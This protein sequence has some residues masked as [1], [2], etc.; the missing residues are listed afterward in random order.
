GNFTDV[1]LKFKSKEILA[2]RVILSA[3]SEVF[4]AM[5]Q[6]NM[7]ETN[8]E[9]LSSDG[10]QVESEDLVLLTY[11]K[12]LDHDW[13]QRSNY[14]NDVFKCV[15]TGF[16]SGQCFDMLTSRFYSLSLST[17]ENI[18]MITNDAMCVDDSA[19]LDA[20]KENLQPRH[21][22]DTS[23]VIMT[24]GG[25]DGNSCLVSSFAFLPN[26]CNWAHLAPMQ[27]SRH[28]HGTVSIGNDL[29]VAGGFNSR[30]GP[31]NTT[32]HYNSMSNKWRDLGHMHFKR[33]SLGISVYQDK[34]F[35]SG[36]LDENY[37]ALDSVEFYD[38]E[39][40]CWKVFPNMNQARYSHG[41]VGSNQYGLFSIGGWKCAT[42]ERCVDGEW[43][44]VAEMSNPRAG[45]TNVIHGHQIYV[46]GGYNSE[47]VN[48]L[49]IYNIDNGTWTQGAS[50]SVARW[51]AGYAISENTIYIIGG[52]DS[53]WQ[54]L[55]TVESYDIDT[56]KWNFET[57][58]PCKLMGLRCSVVK[59]PKHYVNNIMK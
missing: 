49:E 21:C 10:I 6:T 51:R 42:V 41:F 46:C 24:T 2:H 57:P 3:A 29:F 33:K 50:A 22:L 5:F 8:E 17:P 16:L 37:N 23:T 27:T 26:E 13:K 11:L 54:Y 15:R 12:W 34:L 28:D 59:V 32:E 45:A 9:V 18:L 30:K 40:R 36:G 35:V 14:F 52:R 4:A 38:D 31:L 47:C 39:S 58:L 44:M 55:D 48:S 25:Y 43:R 20:S 19:T 7:K 56:N 1:L 53:T